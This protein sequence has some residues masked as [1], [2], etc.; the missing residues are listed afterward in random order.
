MTYPVSQD[1]GQSVSDAI[2]L[3]L[4]GPSG[5]GQN[6]QGVSAYKPTY[7]TSFYR[8]PFTVTDSLAQPSTW[9]SDWPPRWYFTPIN[10]TN[11]Y[12]I[13]V[14]AGK[15]FYF[16]VEFTPQSVPPFMPGEAANISGIVDSSGSG[17]YN[18]Y[19]NT[20]GVQYCTTSY[21]IIK[22]QS[23]YSYPTYVSGGTINTDQS[24]G[25]V[26]TDCNAR[27]TIT[28]GTDTVFITS[29]NQFTFDY[30]CLYDTTLTFTIVVNRYYG[31][32]DTTDPTNP[33]YKFAKDDRDGRDPIVSKQTQEWNLTVGTGT[34]TTEKFVFTTILDENIPKGYYWYI[35]EIRFDSTDYGDAFPLSVETGIRSLT[36]Q[37]IKQ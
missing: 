17:F 16:K 5:L 7:L 2:N 10:V 36:A 33:D 23:A 20:P 26:S 28:G 19:Y 15:A 25:D 31:F 30:T 27:V 35:M 34:K 37:V 11:A 32:I 12:P 29:Q 3:L 8:K 1:D 14:V 6:F 4:S 22:T 24:G 18:D 9:N 13:D 21:V